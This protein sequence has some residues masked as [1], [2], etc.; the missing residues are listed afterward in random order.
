MQKHLKPVEVQAQ[1]VT[2]MIEQ[3]KAELQGQVEQ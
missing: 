3:L 2:D 1:R